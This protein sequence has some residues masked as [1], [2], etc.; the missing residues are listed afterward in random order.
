MKPFVEGMDIKHYARRQLLPT[1]FRINGAVDVTWRL[2]ILEKKL[3]YTGK[4]QAYVMPVE[5]SVDVD[6]EM[7]FVFLKAYMEKMINDQVSTD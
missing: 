4:M 1:V 7:D 2:T 5:R 3:L 6:T